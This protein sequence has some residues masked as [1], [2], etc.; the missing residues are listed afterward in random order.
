MSST[1]YHTR[2][3]ILFIIFNRPDTTEKV[4]GQ[5][6]LT[7]PR[8]LYI[9]ADGP[10]EDS[11]DDKR[12]CQLT[13][14]V[15]KKVDW[16]C[17]VKT[18]FKEANAGCKHGVSAAL[19]WFFDQEDEG[20]VLEDDC[21]PANSFF[22]FCD[23]LLEKYRDDHRVRHITGCNLQFGRKWGDGNY[24][25]SNRVHVWGWASWK[26][27]WR[28]YDLNLDKYDADG[29]R[30]AMLNIYGD[31]VVA[32]AWTNIFID[33]KAGE[34]NSWAYPL[35]FANFFNNGLVIIPNENLISNI[36]FGSGGTHTL[37][38][39]SIY[40]NIPF[41]ELDE[42]KHPAFMVPQKQAD[43]SIINRD[44]DIAIR[45]RKQNAWHRR[46]KRWFKSALSPLK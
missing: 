13:R 36:G 37:T 22:K 7:Q 27:V 41:G 35:D 43:L 30:E 39:E 25:F 9:T 8:R 12:L 42:I 6:R 44:F 28:E 29:V 18:L 15:V 17:E 5:I 31:D 45:R 11:Q 14:D 20:I 3:A 2:S 33:Q 16:P 26:R 38:E 19:D 32:D 1:Q 23:D 24:Y 46:L 40:A 21:L 4:F 10:R 34:T